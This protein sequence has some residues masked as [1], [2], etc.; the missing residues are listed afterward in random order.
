ML[1]INVIELL[2]YKTVKVA[3]L[4]PSHNF[5]AQQVS[6]P[7]A[8]S[9]SQGLSVSVC[10]SVCRWRSCL[11]LIMFTDV[12]KV[13]CVLWFAESKLLISVHCKCRNEFRRKSPHVNNVHQWLKQFKETGSFVKGKTFGRCAVTAAQI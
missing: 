13:Q 7:N 6:P 9:G 10:L 5:F 1:N 3:T 8:H 11:L 4:I 2:W 12:E